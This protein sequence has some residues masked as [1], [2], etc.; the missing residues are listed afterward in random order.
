MT[1]TKNKLSAAMAGAAIGMAHV[2]ALAI[3]I[4]VATNAGVRVASESVQTTASALTT[5]AFGL[6]GT[7]T[8]NQI[9]ASTDIRVTVTLSSGTFGA[10]PTLRITNSAGATNTTNGCITTANTANSGA[11][12]AFNILTGGGT[13]DSTVTFNTNTTSA[14][15]VQAGAHF[16]FDLGGAG[17]VIGT[18]QAAITADVGIK[19]ADNFGPTDLPG[20]TAEPYVSFGPVGSVVS[21]PSPE[22]TTQINAAA[23][24]QKPRGSSPEGRKFCKAALNMQ[25]E[26]HGGSAYND[27]HRKSVLR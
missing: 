4:D 9:P 17:L 13:A 14:F 24:S 3:D 10:A 27:A 26:G 15:I 2:P 19:I 11:C 1:F 12:P 18:S 8:A 20:F 7:L 23:S 5:A 16:D 25:S 22:P 6:E 21:D